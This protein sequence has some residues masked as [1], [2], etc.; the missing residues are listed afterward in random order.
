MTTQTKTFIELPDILAVRVE[1]GK[2]HSTV[3]MPIARNMNFAGMKRCPNCGNAWLAVEMSSI[4]PQIK[5]CAESIRA[6]VDELKNWQKTLSTMG[7]D[8]FSLSLEIK[9]K[10]PETDE[11]E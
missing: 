11:E 3:T 5:A 4:E 9:G 6:T 8:G 7:S 1:C 10:Q 2:C